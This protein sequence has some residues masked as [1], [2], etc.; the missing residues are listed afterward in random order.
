MT[1]KTNETMSF[2]LPKEL[3]EQL[4]RVAFRADTS[5]SNVLKQ[6]L[7][8]PHNQAKLRRAA[9]QTHKGIFQ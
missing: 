8:D 7:E 6:L 9:K 3:T 1:D 5:V 2:Y 4:R